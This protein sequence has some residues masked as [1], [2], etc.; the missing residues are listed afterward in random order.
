MYMRSP[1]LTTLRNNYLMLGYYACFCS[2]K[3]LIRPPKTTVP[4][5]LNLI[6]WVNLITYLNALNW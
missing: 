5:G 2:S 4:D 1:D 6:N 3:M